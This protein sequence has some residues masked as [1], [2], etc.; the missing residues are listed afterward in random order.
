M[1]TYTH[2]LLTMKRD[3]ED[4]RIYVIGAEGCW[5]E[6]GK[7]VKRERERKGKKKKEILRVARAAVR[8]DARDRFV[9]IANHQLTERPASETPRSILTSRRVAWPRNLT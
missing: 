2:V 3:T 7:K 1:R 8:P 4:E 9:L 5:K 6:E